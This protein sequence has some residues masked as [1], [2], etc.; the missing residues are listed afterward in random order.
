MTSYD[1]LV[2]NQKEE[3]KHFLGELLLRN[4]ITHDYFNRE[5]HLR[6]LIAL[7]QNYSEGALDVYKQLAMICQDRGLLDKYV[8]KN[9]RL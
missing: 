5:I 8:D 6:K 3:E 2:N 4:E 1:T 7:M 9:A